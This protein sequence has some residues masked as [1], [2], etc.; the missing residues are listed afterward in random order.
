M[1]ISMSPRH[2]REVRE[3]LG[4]TQAQF[5]RTINAPLATV[6]NWEQ[7]RTTVPPYVN[8]LLLVMDREPEAVLRALGLGELRA[9]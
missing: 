6:K 4:M 3:Q 2:P 9:P 5:A 1:S 7:G 8:T